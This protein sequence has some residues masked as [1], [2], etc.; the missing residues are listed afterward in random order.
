MFD[1]YDKLQDIPLPVIVFHIQQYLFGNVGVYILSGVVIL[2]CLTTAV[3]LLSACG[4]YFSR[5]LAFTK[6]SYQAWVVIFAVISAWVA[7]VG[8]SAL[9]AASVPSLYALYPMVISIVTLTFLREYM[10]HP[11]LV[12]RLVMAVSLVMGLLA[13]VKMYFALVKTDETVE[14]LAIPVKYWSDLTID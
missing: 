11:K 12:Y 5:L 1:G 14:L 10:R 6:L 3:G 2:A 13:A 7:N 4:D 9:I 8:L